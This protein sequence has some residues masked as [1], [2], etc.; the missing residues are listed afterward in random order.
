MKLC[1]IA[2]LMVQCAFSALFGQWH[3]IG[4]IDSIGRAG[5]AELTLRAGGAMVTIQVLAA[6]PAETKLYLPLVMRALTD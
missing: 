5:P 4:A 6:P 1:G 3:S 2:L